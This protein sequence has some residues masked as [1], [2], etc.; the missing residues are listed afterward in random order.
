[1]P[2]RQYLYKGRILNLALEGRYEIVEH[3]DAVA[4]LVEREG[5]LLFVRQYRPAIGS[6]TLEIPAGLIDPGETPEEAA[7]RELAEEAQLTG[8]LE[9]LTGFYL[10]PGFCDEKLHVF[11]ATHTRPAYAKPDD[12]EAITVEWHF[13]RQ[14]LRDA[15]EGRVQIS[16]SAL[17]GILFHLSAEALEDGPTVYE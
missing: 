5:K 13:P 10:S 1:M 11:R 7:R 14:V 3:A 9:Y 12:D 17:A 16:A 8:D 4:V 15:R 6:E 2:E